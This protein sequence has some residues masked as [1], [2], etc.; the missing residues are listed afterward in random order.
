MTDPTDTHTTAEAME[1]AAIP[2]SA[3]LRADGHDHAVPVPARL[4]AK[5]QR[6][7]AEWAYQRVIFYLKT[8]EESL[9]ADQEAAMGFTGG[10]AGLMRIQGVGFHAPDIVTFS[11]VDE[12][13][14]RTQS[15]QHVSQLN[16][17][18]RA[19]PKPENQPEPA[20]IGFR[21]ASAL[22]EAEEAETNGDTG[23]RDSGAGMG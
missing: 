21:L 9:D 11:G 14:F 17:L 13:G 3:E 12:R 1:S 8:F 15:V 23:H 6:S 20:R 4:A 10:V 5:A 16:I 2:R 7:P 22:E 19:V 18:L